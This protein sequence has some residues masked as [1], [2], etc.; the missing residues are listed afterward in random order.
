MNMKV[1]V[2]FLLL[3]KADIRYSVVT[4]TGTATGSPELTAAT[5]PP[6]WIYVSSRKGVEL[7]YSRGTVLLFR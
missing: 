6:P 3:D 5:P 4:V 7:S 2:S 1:A